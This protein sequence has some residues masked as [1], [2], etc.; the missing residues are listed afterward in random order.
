VERVYRELRVERGDRPRAGELVRTGY[1]LAPL[2]SRHGSWFEFVRAEGDLPADQ[3]AAFDTHA[4]FLRELETTEMTKSF[5]MIT[6]EALLESSALTTGMPLR[7]LAL[8]A[9]AILRR[10]S[11]LLAD[12]AD[13]HRAETPDE[14]RWLAYWRRNPIEAWTAPK[15]DRRAW[16]R[17]DGERFVPTFAVEPATEPAF[18]ALVRELVDCRLAQ[19]R[20]RSMQSSASAESFVCRVMWNKRDPILKLPGT[21]RDALPQGDTDVRVENGVWQFRFAKEFCNVARPAGTQRNQ[22]PD[23]MRRW[24]GPSAGQ[25]GTA[26]DVRFHAS[27]D[28]LWAD[29][30]QASV[31]E[32]AARRGVVAYPDLR[33]AA[34]HASAA[35]EALEAEHVLL[36]IEDADPSLFAVRVSGTSMDGGRDPLRDGDWA[37]MRLS[38]GAAAAALEN[39]VVLVEVAGGGPGSQYQIKRLRRDGVKWL[40]ASD[41][42]DGPSFAAS[43]ETVPIARLERAFHLEDLAPP[44]STVLTEDELA[45]A[46][47]LDEP[48]RKS[49][50][51]GGHL[52]ILIDAKGMLVAPDR[53]RYPRPDVRPSETAFVLTRRDDG[54]LRY[55]GVGRRTDEPNVWAMPDVDFGTWR[56]WGEGRET[57]RRLPPHALGR[58]QVAAQ[59]L[60]ALDDADRTLVHAEGRRARILGTAQR[61]GLRIDG[62]AGGFAERTVSLLD[63][64][65]VIVADDEVREHGGTLDEARVNRSRYLDG[66]PKGSTRWIDTGWAIAAWSRAKPLVRESSGAAGGV[67]TIHDDD[68]NPLDATFRVEPVGAA[69]TLVLLSRGPQRNSNYTRGLGVMLSRL[70]KHDIRIA[71]ILVDSQEVA[72]L[73]PERRRVAVPQGYPVAVDDPEA[74]RR[75]I[76]ANQAKIGRAPGAKG[77]GNQTRTIRL[78]VEAKGQTVEQL[79]ALVSRGSRTTATAS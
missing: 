3:A 14:A 44:P 24:F 21:N 64:A 77:G 23:L 5:K 12:V 68:G 32:L 46:F 52:F 4:G 37:V 54:T 78:F 26:F 36:P 48:P 74:L 10:S 13:E 49:G 53:V 76:G 39:R 73:P 33:A 75:A 67:R 9:R 59:T 27:P 6:L 22:L 58:A 34:G 66:T 29:P 45:R 30:V 72:A 65:W 63:M 18:T 56:A 28:G 61:G 1:S 55:L 20:R 38:R 51:Y 47:A 16:F 2:R 35:S 11:E 41:N 15:K 8:R 7:E 70:K 19:Y 60:L 17:V 25:P 50:R 79:G 31:V 62:G 42:P 69:L 57:S 43:E 40:L 71:D